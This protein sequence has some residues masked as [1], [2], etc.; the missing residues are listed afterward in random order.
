MDGVFQHGTPTF[1]GTIPVEWKLPKDHEWELDSVQRASG[2]TSL[3]FVNSAVNYDSQQHISLFLF[4]LKIFY[5]Q[6]IYQFIQQIIVF[7]AFCDFF[8]ATKSFLLRSWS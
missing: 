1:T 4:Y 3:P 8:L 6:N 5:E 7:F 2:R